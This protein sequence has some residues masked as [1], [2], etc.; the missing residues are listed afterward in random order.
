MVGCYSNNKDDQAMKTKET[1]QTKFLL[2]YEIDWIDKF[3][4]KTRKSL[5]LGVT[6]TLKSISSKHQLPVIQVKSKTCSSTFSTAFSLEAINLFKEQLEQHPEKF[7][8][9]RIKRYP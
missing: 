1:T 6:D 9:G 3:V 2:V 4:D 5:I 7:N 8:N